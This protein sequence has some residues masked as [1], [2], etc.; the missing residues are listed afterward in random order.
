MSYP[1]PPRNESGRRM[2]N[3]I[4]SLFL[5]LLTA[6]FWIVIPVLI[7]LAGPGPIFYRGERLGLHKRPFTMYKFR[8]LRPDA[9]QIIGAALIT[10]RDKL[11]TPIGRL[12]RDT[13]LD[14]LPQLINVIKGDMNLIGPRPERPAIYE[15]LCKDIP[16]YDNRFVVRPG[17]IGF[18]QMFTPHSS[19]K[20]LRSLIDS[21]YSKRC[22]GILA[23][24]RLLLY[25]IWLITIKALRICREFLSD[26]VNRLTGRY[27]KQNRRELRRVRLSGIRVY[28]RPADSPPDTP[29]IC[30]RLVDMNTEVIL[31][32]CDCEMQIMSPLHLRIERKLNKSGRRQAK[33][34]IVHCEGEITRK[35]SNGNKG[36]GGDYLVEIE[37]TTPLNEF[38]YHKYLMLSSIS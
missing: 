5:I 15:H 3:I 16:G 37:P 17:V 11:E 34:K 29:E 9:E 28:V 18:A 38:K 21:M 6:P 13:R 35:R 2:M 24:G 1:P 26:L 12:L 23:D 36:P 27:G 31:I 25:S 14:E 22:N 8:T 30:G 4:A 20:R 33:R 7:K 19:P 32:H 10:E